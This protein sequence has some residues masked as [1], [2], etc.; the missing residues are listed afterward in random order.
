MTNSAS[1]QRRLATSSFWK[2]GGYR[3]KP[4]EL[5]LYV[6]AISGLVLWSGFNLPWQLQRSTLAIHILVSLLLFPFLVIPF[7]LAHRAILAQSH[8]T[9]LRKTGQ[10]IDYGLFLLSVSGFFLV[11]FGNRGDL[12]G[13]LAY[14]AH[15][16][17]ALPLAVLVIWHAWRW[18][19]LKYAHLIAALILALL[20]I[21]SAAYANTQ[22]GSL[23]VKNGKLFSANFDTGSVSWIDQATGER[24]G[25]IQISGDIRRVA[26][27]G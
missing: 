23:V 15:L 24:L 17:P 3:S 2:R 18:S 8:K 26:L 21:A 16:L 7:W 1:F 11:F 25:E 10:S 4:A 9:S 14:W 27:G 19:M 12:L 5:V 20:S 6:L 22:S 13:Q